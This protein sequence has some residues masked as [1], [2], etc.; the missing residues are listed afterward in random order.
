MA[1]AGEY[2]VGNGPA[3]T[4]CV[5]SKPRADPIEEES[6]EAVI[7]VCV[8]LCSGEVGVGVGVPGD[9]SHDSV[10]GALLTRYSESCPAEG[11]ACGDERRGKS[12]VPP[13]DAAAIPVAIDTV[14]PK[15]RD[16]MSGELGVE[17]E[18][19][20]VSLTCREW[21]ALCER[22]TWSA[23]IITRLRRLALKA[24]LSACVSGSS[25]TGF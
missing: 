17:Y 4:N 16:V 22:V 5:V 13:S 25:V 7:C 1:D 3:P 14:R 23:C 8:K 2:M 24:D 12:G 20:P 6:S 11:C 18:W 10:P 19:E 9:E 15:E 21:C